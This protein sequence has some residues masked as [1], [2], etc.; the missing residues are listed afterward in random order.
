MALTNRVFSD[1][2]RDK[3]NAMDVLNHPAFGLTDRHGSDLVIGLPSLFEDYS[4]FPATDMI[5]KSDTYEVHAEVPGF[6]RNNIKI[7]VPDSRTLVLSGSMNKEVKSCSNDEENMD[8]DTEQRQQTSPDWWINERVSN[9]F[10]RSFTFPKS[11]NPDDIKATCKNG[12][13][14]IVVPKFHKPH[15]LIQID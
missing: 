6:D 15:K 7:E 10:S 14:K 3:R 5:E 1:T 12:V 9:S 13:L 8:V 2:L 4:R 11:I